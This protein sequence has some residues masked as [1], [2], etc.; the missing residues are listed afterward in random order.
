[1]K[2][3]R[4]DFFALI[5]DDRKFRDKNEKPDPMLCGVFST[6]QEARECGAQT[7]GCVCDHYIKKCVVSV[8]FDMLK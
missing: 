3:K 4:K 6:K 8:E 1:M 5:C 2:I 7:E